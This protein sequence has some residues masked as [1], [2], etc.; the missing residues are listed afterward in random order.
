MKHLLILS[1]IFL[2]LAGFAQNMMTPEL[3]WDLKRVG[4][5]EV[6]PDNKS[7]LF[8]QKKY[9]LSSNTSVTDYYIINLGSKKI[10]KIPNLNETV[11]NVIWRPD[12][13]KLGLI[14]NGNRGENIYEI[15]PDGSELKCISSLEVRIGEFKYSPNGKRV[16]FTTDVKLDNF[17]SKELEKDLHSSN[18]KVYDNLMYRHWSNY[19]DGSYT[20]L[21]FTVIDNGNVAGNGIDITPGEKFDISLKP[22]GGIEE[23]CFS[24]DGS[25]IVYTS[26]KMKGIDYA[27]STNSDIY[28]YNISK[29]ETQNL[30][31][32]MMGYDTSP[33]YSKDGKY[34]GWLSMD[35][36]G[37]ESDKNDIII[38]NF[39]ANKFENLTS[40]IDLTVSNFVW[41]DDGK[42]IFFRAAIEGTYQF[43]ELNVET[44][45][46]TMISQGDHNYTSIAFAGDKLIGG[47]QSMNHP[48]DIYAVTIANSSEKQLTNV[49]KS[50]YDN[51]KVGKIEK[52]WVKTSDDLKQLV[53][54]IYPPNFD[55]TKKY[56]ALLYCQG[57][58]QSAVSQFFSYRWNFQLMAANGYIVI[59]PNRRGLPGFG[60]KWND[61]ISR[62]WGGQPMNDYLSA[63]DELKKEPFIDESKI[64]AV[65][66]SYG[67]YSVYYLAGIHKNRF[68]CFI[69]HCGLFNLESWYGTTEELF[70]ANHDIGGMYYSGANLPDGY[71]KNSPHRGVYKWNTP[72][73]IFQGEKD[74]RVPMGQGLEAFQALQIKGIQSRLILFPDEN[75]WVL[76][77][78]NGVF[79]HRQYYAWLEKYL[80]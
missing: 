12:G 42:K 19:A 79:W 6:S 1:L 36:D 37:F 77:P 16:M 57:G 80:K 48:T 41:N 3:L 69:S 78:Q 15:K 28:I 55:K 53:W 66:A 61:D 8:S 56:P 70:F 72:M 74:Y 40:E 38:Y 54:I 63:V 25:E 44:K 43:F 2:S 47:K 68:A 10:T 20:H 46:H 59:A 14:M 62:D 24:P 39:A 33:T 4:G 32:G 60:Q 11:R 29:R 26:K 9:E 75:H 65:G 18:A 76:S 49:N 64:G 23:A 7:V 45:Q 58:P 13:Q 71:I 31:K 50:I 35:K 34:L 73:L 52:R 22:F 51:L 27:T 21:F 67:G 17:H 5:I 30:T